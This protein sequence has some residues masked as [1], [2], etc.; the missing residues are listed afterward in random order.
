MTASG[1]SV[2]RRPLPD[3]DYSALTADTKRAGFTCGDSEIDKWFR[4]KALAA[5]EARKH[6]VTCASFVGEPDSV[7]GFYALS[8]VVEDAKKLPGV[9][10]YSPFSDRQFPCIQLTYMA[11]RRDL[12]RNDEEYGTTVLGEVVRTFAEIGEQIGMPAMI[13]TPV[14]DDARR[15]YKRWDFEPYYHN[16]RMFLPLQTAIATLAA[17]EA[18]ALAEGLLEP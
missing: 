15:F 10:Y 8:A 6:L 4:N 7:V 16:N 3:I 11:I 12:Q 5:H 9:P 1:V 13:L 17:A 18:E 14:N 2:A